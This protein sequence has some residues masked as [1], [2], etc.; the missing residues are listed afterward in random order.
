MRAPRSS[1]GCPRTVNPQG[2]HLTGG[3]S[4][5]SSNRIFFNYQLT[6]RRLLE[7]VVQIT[8]LGRAIAITREQMHGHAL[9]LVLHKTPVMSTS[10]RRRTPKN[11]GDFGNFQ[12]G[13]P[14]QISQY[15]SAKKIRG[16]IRKSAP[17]KSSCTGV[18]TPHG[19]WHTS[20]IRDSS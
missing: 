18:P 11:F 2:S 15:S 1:G 13:T 16:Q 5:N 14:H 17:F 6:C 4:E 10:Q 20:L 7:T 9:K 3:F 19:N 8:F 12:I